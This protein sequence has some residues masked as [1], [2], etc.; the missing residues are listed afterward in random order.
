MKNDKYPEGTKLIW[1]SDTMLLSYEG[2]SLCGLVV[3]NRKLPGDICVQWDTGQFSSYDE[4]YL[5]E[6]T[7]KILPRNGY[8][9]A[10]DFYHELGESPGGCKVYAS[11]KDISEYCGCAKSCG[12][13]K[14]KITFEE[15][16][17]MGDESGHFSF[18][19]MDEK[20]ERYLNHVRE[21]IQELN[22]TILSYQHQISEYK[23]LLDIE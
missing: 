6:N 2:Q 8:M 5:D 21:S 9:C 3:E 19:E 13:V 15:N 11:E 12:V 10:T 7:I 23:K 18:A 22:K 1:R 14:V 4:E 16:A 17:L 20:S